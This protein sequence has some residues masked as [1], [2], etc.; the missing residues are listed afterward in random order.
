MAADRLR[1]GKKNNFAWPNFDL[2][3]FLSPSYTGSWENEMSALFRFLKI[4]VGLLPPP[5]H[6]QGVGR[7]SLWGL[8]FGSICQENFMISCFGWAG[9]FNVARG[10]TL[11]RGVILVT[12]F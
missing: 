6:N 1:E 7:S 11:L 12:W 4:Y 8:L 9:G 2:F 5:P 3:F 10:E